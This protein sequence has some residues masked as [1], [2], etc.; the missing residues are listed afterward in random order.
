ML[1]ARVRQLQTAFERIAATRM[2]GLPVCHPGLRVAAIGFERL[3]DEPGTA[4]GVLVTPWF[5]NL[6][7][8]PL[9]PAAAGTLPERASAA[10][11]VGTQRFEFVGAFEPG[12]GAFECCSLFSPM[13][14][15][16]DAPAAEATAREVLA[17]LRA[18]RPAAAAPAAPSRRG[19]LFGAAA[20]QARP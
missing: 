3:A 5:M 19:F 2:A 17:L 4:C 8:L 10:R 12:P 14:E 15:F 11:A 13:A 9:D 6:V 18:P 7:R 1:E 16:A 20:P